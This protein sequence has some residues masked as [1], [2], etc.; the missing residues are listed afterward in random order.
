MDSVEH[1]KVVLAAILAGRGRQLTGFLDYASARLTPD[2]FTDEVQGKLFVLCQRY[3]DQARGILPRDVLADVLRDQAPGR[4]LQFT[5]YYDALCTR[6]VTVT[7]F[8]WSVSQ[9]RDLAADRATGHAL[10]Q[11]MEILRSGAHDDDGN[12]LRGHADA[13]A[14]VL[15]AFSEAESAL[16]AA[17]SPEGDVRSE[18][19]QILARY[20]AAKTARLSSSAPGVLFGITELDNRLKAGALP[21][22]LTII[23]GWT[24][25]GKTSYCV[26]W[27]HHVAVTQ[28]RD[29]AYFTTETLRP[30]VTAK[31]IA[32]HSRES[33]F[34]SLGLTQGLN[35]SAILAGTLTEEQEN[36]FKVVLADFASAGYGKCWVVQTP[37][38]ATVGTFEARLA[39]IG[40]Q[41]RPALVVMDY[42]QLLS[43]ERSHRDGRV[44]EDQAGVVKGLKE[45]AATFADGSG[46]PVVT[47]WQVSRE[48]RKSKKA[49]GGYDLLDVAETK[50]AADTADLVIA[51]IDP[52]TDTTKGRAVPIEAAVIKNRDGERNFKAELTVDF[53]TSW[54]G[55][56]SRITDEGSDPFLG[57]E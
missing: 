4:L 23:L 31:L 18:A 32:R 17:E 42:A 24:S 41:F 6:E 15:A 55:A 30:Q 47:P 16:G 36:A 52:E 51:L 14:H 5:E 54:F 20:A 13:R 34:A 22:S 3:A 28:G 56:R 7:S 19:Q 11:G 38:A 33:R 37:R 43:P 57:M 49:T 45:A 2:H 26:N 53:A 10:A 25:A 46:V 35:S 8:K 9:L 1:G 12:F 27:A 39:A 29:V 44:H 50:V 40:R 21:G 48:G